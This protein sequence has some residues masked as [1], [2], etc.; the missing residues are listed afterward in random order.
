MAKKM[1]YLDAGMDRGLERIARSENTSVSE[2]VSLTKNLSND[3]LC[4]DTVGIRSRRPHDRL[5]KA[6]YDVARY[7]QRMAEHLGKPSSA[8]SFRDII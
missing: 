4:P 8:V 3:Q 5:R 6:Y 2:G 7:D 1:I